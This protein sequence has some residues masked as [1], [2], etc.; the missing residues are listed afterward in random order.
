MGLAHHRETSLAQLCCTL[1]RLCAER[2]QD[3]KVPSQE[4]WPSTRDLSDPCNLD[5]YQ[6]RKLLLKLVDRG[7]AQRTARS[8]N[9]ALRWFV[10]DLTMTSCPVC[11][12]ARP[13]PGSTPQR[14]S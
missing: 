8:V 12:N 11:K 7:I 4:Q 9:N 6:G 3:G 10:T 5:I 2:L 13:A 1:H 14:P